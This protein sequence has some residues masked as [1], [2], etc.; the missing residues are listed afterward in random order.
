MHINHLR[1]PKMKEQNNKMMQT[2]VVGD[3]RLLMLLVDAGNMYVSKKKYSAIRRVLRPDASN[4]NSIMKFQ[5]NKFD[6]LKNRFVSDC[7]MKEFEFAR[8]HYKYSKP[9]NAAKFL[10]E[11]LK[12]NKKEQEYARTLYKN[13]YLP[14]MSKTEAVAARLL[15]WYPIYDSLKEKCF[16][17][18]CKQQTKSELGKDVNAFLQSSEIKY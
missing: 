3:W 4:Y 2:Q 14:R 5:R 16:S 7:A 10:F 13:E 11:S 9:K 17:F 18:K 12:S 6:V 1:V 8:I 15:L